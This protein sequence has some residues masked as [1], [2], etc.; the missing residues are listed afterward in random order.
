MLIHIVAWVGLGA[1]CKKA[2]QP[3]TPST[4]FFHMKNQGQRNLQRYKI[5]GLLKVHGLEQGD[6]SMVS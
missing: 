4:L 6:M 3:D 1:L 2:K 5:S